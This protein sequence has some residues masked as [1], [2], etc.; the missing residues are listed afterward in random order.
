MKPYTSQILLDSARLESGSCAADR[1]G[2]P[3]KLIFKE[4]LQCPVV[5]H[6]SAADVESQAVCIPY[7]AVTQRSMEL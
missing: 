5:E 2:Y 7:Q 1:R 3:L 4:G 6:V